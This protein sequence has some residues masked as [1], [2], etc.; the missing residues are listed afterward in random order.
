M[1]KKINSTWKRKRGNQSLYEE[2]YLILSPV[3]PD[4]NYEI[5][6]CKYQHFEWELMQVNHSVTNTIGTR[7][8]WLHWRKRRGIFEFW[9]FIEANLFDRLGLTKGR[10]RKRIERLWRDCKT[11]G[12]PDE[13]EEFFLALL[14]D[15]KSDCSAKA[16]WKS[17]TFIRTWLGL[18]IGY[19]LE[20]VCQRFGI[21]L[22]GYLLFVF[23]FGAFWLCGWGDCSVDDIFCVFYFG[24]EEIHF[25][26]LERGV[27]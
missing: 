23:G 1:R 17:R 2:Y 8:T 6:N 24:K 5:R 22:W 15:N 3:H 12:I 11:A 10:Q 20:V 4:L 26:A 13:S 16:A 14:C 7:G 18:E 25:W 19:I 21:W 27:S 9:A